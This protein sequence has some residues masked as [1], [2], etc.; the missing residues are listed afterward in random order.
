MYKMSM[1]SGKNP[2]KMIY[3]LIAV[4]ILIEVIKVVFPLMGTAIVS[5]GSLANFT[6]SGLFASEG[7]VF[8][9]LSALVLIGVLATLGI[10][11]L[12]SKR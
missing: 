11:N 2:F 12:G 6:F 8:I 4:L 9:V 7:L 5:L 3:V 10:K 1:V